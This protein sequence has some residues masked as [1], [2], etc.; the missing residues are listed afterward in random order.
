MRLSEP[1]C[2]QPGIPI[3]GHDQRVLRFKLRETF[4]MVNNSFFQIIIMK[5]WFGEITETPSLMSFNTER[6][7]SVQVA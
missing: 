4:L 1:S 6:T 7:G 2:L 5:L 3:R